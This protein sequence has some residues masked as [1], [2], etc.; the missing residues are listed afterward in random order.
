LH[1]ILHFTFLILH[2]HCLLFLQNQLAAAGYSAFAAGLV[3]VVDFTAANRL[4]AKDKKGRPAGRPY[5]PKIF[6]KSHES[7]LRHHRA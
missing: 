7:R 3:Y 4:K 6:Q 1:S 5:F 2:Y